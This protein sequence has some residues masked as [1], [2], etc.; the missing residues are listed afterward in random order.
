MQKICNII[1]NRYG[2][3][4]RAHIELASDALKKG[5]V[6]AVPTD[7]I[8]GLAVRADDTEALKKIYHIKGRDIEK[9]LAVA[10]AKLDHI[11]KI[12]N[13]DEMQER[14]T[15]LL[16]PGPVTLLLNRSESLNK[17]L[18]PG[19]EK[20]GIRIPDHHLIIELADL[21]GPIALT[22]ANK[23]GEKNPINIEDFEEIW[24]QLDHIFDQ[25]A[26]QKHICPEW[27]FRNNRL[28][29]TVVD[30]T[31]PKQ[32]TIL[33]EGLS[34]NRTISVLHRIGLREAKK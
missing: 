34:T 14:A 11:K 19:I 32:F 12:A 16:L 5:G 3:V 30:L 4:D 17:N 21:V 9:P 18:N 28:G 20:V 8:Y 1:P 24:N 13:I 33:R 7:T 6:I 27:D 25:G 22:S 29:S 26:L 23:S 10:V 15:K 31:V 2:L